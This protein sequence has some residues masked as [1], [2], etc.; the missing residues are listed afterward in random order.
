MAWGDDRYGGDASGVDLSSGVVEAM[1]GG[2]A[3][4]AVKADGSAV[5]WGAANRAV[6]SDKP[7]ACALRPALDTSGRGVDLRSGVVTATCGYTACVAVKQDTS[8]VAWGDPQ[9]GGDASAVDLSSGVVSAM[10][11]GHACVAVK[12]DGSAVTWG[13]RARGG[14]VRFSSAFT[15]GAD[16]SSGVATAMCGWE[17]CV[18]VKE[19]TSAVAWGYKSAG[20]DAAGISTETIT[21]DIT[22]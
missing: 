11:G 1:C 6:C 4:V 19:D 7:P 17:A 20:G 10:C 22:A 9:Y 13:D 3:C 14:D 5:T 15:G 16:L 12:A 8:A 21:A 2:Y 18:A